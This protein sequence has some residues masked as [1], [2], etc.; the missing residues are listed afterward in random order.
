ML[1]IKM[2][3]LMRGVLGRVVQIQFWILMFVQV[4]KYFEEFLFNLWLTLTDDRN[5]RCMRQ[6]RFH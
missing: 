5:G 3:K 4:W 2:I 6:G 1:C